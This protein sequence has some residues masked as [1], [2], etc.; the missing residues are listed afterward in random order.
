MTDRIAAESMA[1]P[2]YISVADAMT[3][4]ELRRVT[5]PALALV[6]VWIGRTRLTDNV[7]L[8]WDVA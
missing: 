5:G 6:A 3:L 7:P 1:R 4:E 8:A 2:D